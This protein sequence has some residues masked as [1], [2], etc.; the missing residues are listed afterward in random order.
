MNGAENSGYKT[1]PFDIEITRQTDP[2]VIA[3]FL[4][5]CGASIISGDC[6]TWPNVI[7]GFQRGAAR[8]LDS[9]PAFPMPTA[10]RGITIV[11]GG[12]YL[13][14]VYVTV[15]VL[16]HVGCTLP[17]DV[18]HFDGENDACIEDAIREYDVTFH[19]ADQIQQP[20]PFRFLTGHWWQGWQLKS[21]ALLHSRFESTLLL[22]ADN[23]PTR[24]PEY[25]FDWPEFLEH[26]AVIWPDQTNSP[27]IMT[28]DVCRLFEI[29]PSSGPTAESGQLLVN[30]RL[31]WQQLVLAGYYNQAADLAY[32]YIWG[33][34]DTFP[35]AFHRTQ[36]HFARM[37][38]V[39]QIIPDCIL[40]YDFNGRVIF[41][42][43]CS[44]KFKLVDNV[45][46]STQQRDARNRYNPSLVHEAFCFS[47]LDE[48]RSI[49]TSMSS[50]TH[51][52]VKS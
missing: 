50:F 1:N 41:Q 11:G 40:Q 45:F 27:T 26:G 36:T 12:K 28:R 52:P 16:R 3:E 30:R 25:L 8:T 32:R 49:V 24:D 35:I 15:R 20:R 19:N 17:I 29:E 2:S 4:T 13:A 21:F 51:R 37:W 22:D 14:S 44:D 6:A 42:H 10:P 43:R 23:Y 39:C 9:I 47:V 48:L 33:D 5:T 34:K 31:C 7:T 38:P 46:H 18:W